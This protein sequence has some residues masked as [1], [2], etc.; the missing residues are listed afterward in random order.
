MRLKHVF[1]FNAL[2][3]LAYGLGLLAEPE[4]ILS[5]HGSEVEPG[6]VLMGRFFA[7]A[8]L[9][10]GLATWLARNARNSIAREGLAIG[11]PLSYLAGLGVALHATLTGLMGPLGWLPVGVYTLLVAGYGLY[12]SGWIDRT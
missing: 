4:T 2:V 10:I 7:V 9:G 8:L 1:V 5:W 11:L 3:A 6:A 12:L